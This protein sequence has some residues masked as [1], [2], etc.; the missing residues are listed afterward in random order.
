MTF[1]TPILLM[2]LLYLSLSLSSFPHRLHRQVEKREGR[3]KSSP[4]VF[5]REHEKGRE[6]ESTNKKHLALF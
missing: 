5:V 6:E 1:N 3:K 2:L 4:G